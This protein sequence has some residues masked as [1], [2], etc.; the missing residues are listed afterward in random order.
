MRF[1]ISAIALR[2]SAGRA[3][4]AFASADGHS[5]STSGFEQDC[6]S[7]SCFSRLTSARFSGSPRV[8]SFSSF[9]WWFTA[10]GIACW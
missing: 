2:S 4:A 10:F 8:T 9:P 3:W 6:D 1:T 5:S 7:A